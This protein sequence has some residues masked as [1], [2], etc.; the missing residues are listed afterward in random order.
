MEKERRKERQ[1][2][3]FTDGSYS[4]SRDQGGIGIVFVKDNKEILRYSKMF[5]HVSN[6]KMELG[7][8]IVGLRMIKKP[9]ESLTVYS[10]S[11]YCIGS[12]TQGW[13]RNK[14]KLLWK[15][16]DEEYKRVQELCPNIEFKHVKGHNGSYWN[17]LVDS[18]C[19]KASQELD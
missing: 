1:Y 18:I 15:A 10:D 2:E 5:K 9:I 6:N 7:A 12:I 11:M 17:E 13:K 3:L 19:V 8:I 16:F 4:S 14:N